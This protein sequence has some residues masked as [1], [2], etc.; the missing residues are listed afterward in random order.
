MGEG[1]ALLVVHGGPSM[2]HDY[3]LPQLQPLATKYKLIFY[4]QRASGLSPIPPDSSKDISYRI[5]VDDIEALRNSFGIS[6]LN[7]M[8]HSWGAKLAVNYALQYPEHLGKL[9]F[10]SPLTFSHEYDSLQIAT[11]AAKTTDEDK[12]QRKRLVGSNA[13]IQGDMGVYKQVLM[14]MYKTSF[15][16]TSNLKHLNIVLPDNF[17]RAN[18]VLT[19]G[20]MTD[21]ERYDRNYYPQLKKIKAS[22]LVLHGMADNLPLAAAERLKSTV[23]NGKLVVFQKSGHFPFVEE[24]DKFIE[25]VSGFMSGK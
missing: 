22:L 8:A 14:L 20:L 11:I 7:I 21:L 10:I 2:N 13:F 5:M 3:F 23:P 15:Y 16:D 24:Q 17:Y 1:E 19:R 9:I 25:T 12:D 18:A 4:D 6:K